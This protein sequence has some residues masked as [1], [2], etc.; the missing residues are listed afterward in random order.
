MNKTT[1]GKELKRR[2]RNHRPTKEPSEPTDV[3]AIM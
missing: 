3:E 1:K 2:P